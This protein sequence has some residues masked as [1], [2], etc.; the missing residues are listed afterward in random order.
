MSADSPAAGSQSMPPFPPAWRSVSFGANLLM[1][2]TLVFVA[3]LLA[4]AVLVMLNSQ[5]FSQ[6]RVEGME[7]RDRTLPAFLLAA[8]FLVLMGGALLVQA[9]LCLF[10]LAPSESST[11]TFAL[12]S[13]VCWLLFLV[14]TLQLPLAPMAGMPLRS[15]L[16]DQ[17]FRQGL[18]PQPILFV[19]VFGFT[20]AG[21]MCAAAS[22]CFALTYVCGVAHYFR[23][24]RLARSGRR[25]LAYR[26]VALPACVMA[27]FVQGFIAETWHGMD[28]Y[29]AEAP[30]VILI[31][32]IMGF[33]LAWLWR[34]LA[35]TRRMLRAAEE[36]AT[37]GA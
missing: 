21:L 11:R 25:L 30:C 23:N 18:D 10:C 22:E 31:L 7:N 4:L 24:D 13:A 32:V 35:E 33:G 20:M 36:I 37:E 34:V 15:R 3:G 28:W 26:I 27:G 29:W 12:A 1:A 6:P 16:A 14:I 19:N 2:G 17:N 9:S 8:A 5:L